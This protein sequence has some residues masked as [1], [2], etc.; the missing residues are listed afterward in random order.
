ML[1]GDVQVALEDFPD[2]TEFPFGLQVSVIP[3]TGK[4][5]QCTVFTADFSG[6]L[7]VLTLHD[8]NQG[9]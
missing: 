5:R 9:A 8:K 6:P 4:T 7:V 3:N 1:L 2:A